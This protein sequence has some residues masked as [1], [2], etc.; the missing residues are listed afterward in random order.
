MATKP[1]LNDHVSLL[2]ALYNRIPR[3]G[4][5]TALELQ[6][7]LECIGLKRDI[8]TIQRNLDILVQHLNVEKDSR[9]KPY[10]YHRD[11]LPV[12]TFGP[13]ESMLLHLAE[14]WLTKSFPVEY[15]AT[16]NSIFS[17]IHSLK[18]Q[19]NSHN[20][21]GQRI[22]SEVTA[23]PLITEYSSKFNAVFEQ[24]TYGIIRQQVVYL[25]IKEENLR[26]EPLGLFIADNR[27]SVIFKLSTNDFQHIEIEKIQ[28]ASLSTFNFEYPKN[29]NL[30]LY[31]KQEGFKSSLNCYGSISH[32]FSSLNL[33]HGND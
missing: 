26:T 30:S 32:R 10:G 21:S 11:T 33:H 14:A 17:E 1:N 23:E 19:T 9:D 3:L 28:D 12:K 7:Q 16:I 22:Y 20:K 4:K 25:T 2:F 24:L 5:I 29:F 15:K 31:Q 8:R 6:K 27:L 18:T 13:R